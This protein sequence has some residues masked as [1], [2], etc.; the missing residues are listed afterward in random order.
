MSADEL[1]F[2]DVVAENKKVTSFGPG[3]VL[4]FI[5]CGSLIALVIASTFANWFS[6]KEELKK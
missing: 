4:A 3:T 5:L 2:V 6:R 1:Q